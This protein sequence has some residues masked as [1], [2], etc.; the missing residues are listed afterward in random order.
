MT[1]TILPFPRPMTVE[2]RL[3]RDWQAAKMRWL[4]RPCL[5]TYRAM[6]KARRAWAAVH[7][8]EL[9]HA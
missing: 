5:E 8:A 2:R 3:W 4:S 9:R 7:W 1:A 6:E